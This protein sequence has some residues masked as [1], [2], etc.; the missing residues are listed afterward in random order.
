[1]MTGV[2]LWIHANSH[3]LV[4]LIEYLLT[5]VQKL[6]G[7]AEFDIETLMGDRRVYIDLIWKGPPVPETDLVE[8]QNDPLPDAVGAL[9][10]GDV[11]EIHGGSIWSQTHRREGYSLLRVPVPSSS[12]QW[13]TPREEL[14]PRPEFYDFKLGAAPDEL[15]DYA[16]VALSDLNYVVF[17]TETT[18]LRPSEGD[19]IISIAGVRIING[20]ILSG[21]TFE[22]LVDPRRTIPRSS[23]RF[24]GI[25][26]E[27]VA[28]KPPIAVVLPQF[29]E[30]LG[31]DVL[32]AHNGAFDM[33]FIRMKEKDSGVR[34]ANP[35]LDTLLLSV[36]LHDH[37]SDHTLEG[38][39]RRLGVEVSGRH[40]ALGDA[41]VTAEI[42][43]HMVELLVAKGVGTLGEALAVSE[44]MVNVRR[45]QAKF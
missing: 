28:N 33:K 10:V 21:E 2:P 41:L 18:G 43:L 11:I 19:E 15:A 22:R 38:I 5:R 12:K 3:A 14:P 1:V 34:F 29:K 39:A 9:T 45:E 23:I 13:E 40:T 36:Y 35:L 6:Y 20:R 42:F 32:V 31:N 27:D 7:L 16:D 37:V 25:T 30:F 4:I 8:W 26:N 17:D 44:K 24:H